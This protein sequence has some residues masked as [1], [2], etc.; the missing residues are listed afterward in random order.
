MLGKAAICTRDSQTMIP[1]AAPGCLA[2]ATA[3]TA[4]LCARGHLQH[5]LCLGSEEGEG[6]IEV[7][8]LDWQR[9]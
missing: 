1:N 3:A 6:F 7:S 4:S 2:S 8:V 5:V 9:S